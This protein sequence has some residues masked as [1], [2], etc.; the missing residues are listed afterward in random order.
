MISINEIRKR[1]YEFSKEYENETRERAEAQSFWNDFFLVFGVIRRRVATFEK[2]V[3]KVNGKKGSIDLFW[4]GKLV[5]EHKSMGEDLDSAYSQATDYFS[6]FD[7][8][9]LPEYVIVSDFKRFRIY[10]HEDD[11]NKEFNLNE[12]AKNIELFGFIYGQEKT[13]YED[14]DPV[15]IM[16]A[17]L[18]GKLYDALKEN[19][20]VNNN[21]GILLIRIM[22]CLFAD[23]TEIF[24]KK[25]FR[26]FLETK[27]KIDGSDVGQNLIHF[28]EILNTPQDKRQKNLDEEL[29]KFDYID[30]EL[31]EEKIDIPNFDSKCREILLK[32]TH[33][34]WSKVSPVV[35]GSLF[36]SVINKEERHKHGGFYTS[37]KNI[38]KVI[39][40]LFLI[41]LEEEYETYKNNTKYLYNMLKKIGNFRLLDPACGCG[42]FLMIAYRELRRLQIK[43]HKQIRKLEGKTHQQLLS[44]DFNFDL[45]VNSL[46]GIELFSFP[47]KIAKVGLWITDHLVNLEFKKELGNFPA[48]IPLKKSANIIQGNA[49]RLDWNNIITKNKLSFIL[50]NPPFISKKER[51]NEQKEDMEIVCNK[52]KNFRLLDYVSCWYIKI[53]DYIQD[54]KIKVSLVSTNSITQGEQVGILWDYLINKK[55]IVIN[56]AHRTFKWSNDLKGKA[57]VY[58]VI[59]GFSLYNN[60]KK[61]IYEYPD[62]NKNPLKIKAKN[63]NPYLIDFRNIFIFSR[64]KP[65]C[66][67]PEI[68]FGNMPNDDGN[69]LFTEKEKNE[70]I[71]QEPR[72]EKYLK[73]YVSADEFLNN[74][75]RWCLWL[76][77]ISPHELNKIPLIKERVIKVKEHR[78][79]SKREATKKLALQPYLFAEIRQPKTNYILIPRHSSEFRD[80]IP[81]G[82][83]NPEFIVADSCLSIPNASLYHFG[84]LNSEMHMVWVKQIC[85]R[86]EGRYRYSNNL[87]YNNFSWIKNPSEKEIKK[88]EK[89][90]K[91]IFSVRKK[92]KC[93]LAEM[94]NQFSMPKELLNVHQKLNRIVDKLY[95]KKSFKSDIERIEH[96]FELYEDYTKSP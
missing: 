18:M 89:C 37:E 21:L 96:L 8:D 29:I 17:E 3:T 56:F 15:N 95:R 62:P 91:I 81:I 71:K 23:D 75:R 32:C 33:F 74:E 4:K 20:Y 88:I 9:D 31:F 1:A 36:Q 2:P 52:I 65:L 25:K 10:N 34:D 79:K 57:S 63:I 55:R 83:F 14:E 72:A 7:D 84:I 28:F 46:Y 59:I 6:K 30:G 80:Y 68:H 60:T 41:D 44:P 39:E 76:K 61:Y 49:L 50:G 47:S 24:E 13:I 51:N 94:Y 69:F 70:F 38:L 42:N 22:F 53:A 43:I 85:G 82:F 40:N 16:A 11:T 90:V 86:L 54:T 27:T 93:S 19:G 67:V 66:Q 48:R 58:V 92:Q 87:V 78:L 45:D 5:V 26:Y 35:F 77:N 73:I 12:L 64:N